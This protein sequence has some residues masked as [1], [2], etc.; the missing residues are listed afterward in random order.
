[1]PYQQ[2]H[3]QYDVL[4]AYEAT[5]VNEGAIMTSGMM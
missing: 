3:K 4:H 2:G 5:Y 1:M